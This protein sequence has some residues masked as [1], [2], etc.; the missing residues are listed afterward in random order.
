MPKNPV[1]SFSLVIAML[2][3]WIA[4]ASIAIAVCVEAARADAGN[5]RPP[6]PRGHPL[7]PAP[8]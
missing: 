8:S 1:V 2:V 5:R 7:D 6:D 3:C 4:F